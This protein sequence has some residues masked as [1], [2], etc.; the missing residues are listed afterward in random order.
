M[1]G[2]HRMALNT[3][4][5]FESRSEPGTFLEVRRALKGGV[6]YRTCPD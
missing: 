3:I 5:K 4:A 2:W 1:V 6:L